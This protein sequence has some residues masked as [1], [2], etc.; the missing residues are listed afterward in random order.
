MLITNLTRGTVIFNFSDPDLGVTSYIG[1]A[2]NSGT[3][4]G[5]VAGGSQSTTQ[6]NQTTTIVLSY[7]TSAMSSGDKL[8]IIIDEQVEHMVPG[9]IFTDPVQKFRVSTPQS[10]I[11]T[12][13]EYS[14][15]PSKWEFLPLVQNYPSFFS[16]GTGGNSFQITAISGGAQSPRS[17]ITVTTASGHGLAT[18]D[19]VAVQE[20][21][22]QLAD[23]TFAITFTGATTFTYVAKGVVSGSILDTGATI[24]YGGGLFDGAAIA[25]SSASGN[26]AAQSLITVTTTN[27][28][29]LLPGTPIQIINATTTGINGTWIITNVS[30]P[31]QFQ[32]SCV[33]VVTTITLGSARLTTSP[34]AYVA[35]R[36]TD[37]GVS[38]TPGGTF[39]GVQAIRQTRRYFRYQSGKAMQFS[40]GAKFTPTHDIDIITG[41]GTTATVTCQ[42][43]HNFQ[44]GAQV[45]IDGIS[46]L[47]GTNFYNGSFVVTSITSTKAFTYT[48][49]GTPTDTAPVGNGFATAINFKGA[50]V[51]A[52]LYDDQNGFFFEYDGRQ[53]F[54]CRRQTIKEMFG[55][56]TGTL[57]SN[58]VTGV[59]TRFRRQFFVGDKIV[60]KGGTYEVQQIDSDT[61]LRISPVYRGPTTGNLRYLRVETFRIPQSQWNMDPANGTG[62]SGYNL[63]ISKMQMAYIDYTWYGAGHVRFGFRGV[64][65]DIVYCHRMPNNN[66]N[67]SAYMR[68][69]NLPARFEIENYGYY[70]KVVAGATGVR[71]AAVGSGD[72]TIFVEDAQNWPIPS[73][74]NVGA[75]IIRDGTNCEVITYTGIGAYNSTAGGY[76]LTGVTRRTSISQ[77]GI[78]IAGAFSTAAYTLSG[79]ASS[80]TFT[81]D[82]GSGGAGA[83]QVSIQEI[84]VTAAPIS[85][86]WGVAVIMDGRYDED[87]SFIFTAGMQR[88]L[89]CQAGVERPLLMI[90]IAPSVD[91]GNGRNFAVREIVNRMQLTLATMGVYSQGQ[92]LIQGKLNPATITGTGLTFPTSWENPVGTVGS[93]SLAQVFYFDG[94][95][96]YATTA[97]PATGAIVGGDRIF[98]FYTENSGGTN[99]SATAQNLE[100]IRD[101]GTSILSGNGTAATPG[102]PNAPDILV[103]TATLLEATGTKNIATRLGWTEAQA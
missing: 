59:S 77:A 35:H 17:T 24:A 84:K 76:P 85:S 52:G 96:V 32:F 38:I 57:N 19:I 2:T 14:V 89:T 6:G 1:N 58:T 54:A 88:Y 18:G 72:T 42:Q 3:F 102:Y 86:H 22:N 16:K 101:L 82:V 61:Q 64:N 43:D 63:D 95:G 98:G 10:M 20:T 23:G 12:D 103:I 34:E 25:M 67:Y 45:L 44:A 28:H 4:N 48:M 27:T 41:S 87:K 73:A 71:G 55:R 39:V 30:T 9:E 83:S 91:S 99:F 74:S 40:T 15:Q 75:A 49:L 62:P 81:P 50:A 79:T 37:G 11:D 66:V 46:V 26:G 80:V 5:L 31:T 93:G 21:L 92:F 65:G 97:T 8:Q 51:R 13:F 100:K 53:L 68:S 70:S 78:N 7:N 94:T 47:S 90:R 60:I 69:G 33:S 36:S 29:G 56:V